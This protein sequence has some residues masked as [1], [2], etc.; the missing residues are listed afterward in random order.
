MSRIRLLTENDTAHQVFNRFLYDNLSYIPF[1]YSR[2]NTAAS[3]CNGAHLAAQRQHK[4][5]AGQGSAGHHNA[6]RNRNVANA[7]QR[8]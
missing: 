6:C 4:Q 1:S 8:T 3:G 5:H 7:H 2:C